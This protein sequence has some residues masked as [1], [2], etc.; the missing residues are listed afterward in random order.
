MET[1]IYVKLIGEGALAYWPVN[2]TR[3]S[4]NVF[5]INGEDIYDPS[6]ETWEFLPGATV[7]VEEIIL[8]GNLVPV[9]VRLYE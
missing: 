4:E 3:L 7:I 6:D 2:A 9:A 5:S 8:S 1:V